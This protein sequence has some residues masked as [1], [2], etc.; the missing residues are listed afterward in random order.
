MNFIIINDIHFGL[1]EKEIAYLEQSRPDAYLFLGD[2]FPEMSRISPFLKNVPRYGIQG[3]H[4]YLPEYRKL[5]D[6][7]GIRLLDKDPVC[8][9]ENRIIL[10]GLSGTKKRYSGMEK[11]SDREI[12]K[13]AY[14]ALTDTA[15][16]TS[17]NKELVK[18][19]LSH[20]SGKGDIEK[21]T[22]FKA[23]TDY[24]KK[25]RPDIHIFGHY[26]CHHEFLA[27]STRCICAYRISQLDIADREN[28]MFTQISDALGRPV[29]KS[30]I[31]NLSAKLTR[32]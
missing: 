2:I 21:G 16:N 26:H 13:D 11:K 30:W 23:I 1:S 28:V 7:Y 20:D 3:N 8:L 29:E 22:G 15:P 25:Y 14:W 4:D 31:S 19:L 27:K 5:Y 32:L 24:R 6:K 17:G 9:D 18:I 12:E 10:T